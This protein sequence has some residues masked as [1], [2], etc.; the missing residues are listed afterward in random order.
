[1]HLVFFTAQSGLTR[2]V[3]SLLADVVYDPNEG[4]EPTTVAPT[5]T[6]L[7]DGSFRGPSGTGQGT[8]LI[9]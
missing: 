2:Y 6:S 9:W 3:D 5:P 4:K 8:E 7:S 1:M